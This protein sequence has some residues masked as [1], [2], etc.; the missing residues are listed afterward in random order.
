MRKIVL[1]LSVLFLLFVIAARSGQGQN[2]GRDM[3]SAQMEQARPPQPLPAP[4]PLDDAYLE[5]PLPP[6]DKAYGSIDG[7][8]IHQYVSQLATIADQYRDQGHQL[9][10]RITGTSGDVAGQQWLIDNF[11]R[12]GLTDVHSQEFDLAPQWIAQSWDVTATGSGKT[13]HLETAQP[14]SGISGTPP[15]GLDLEAVY[16]GLG[17]EA[18]FAGKDVR[19]KAVFVFSAALP[20]MWYNSATTEG[21]LKRA[22]EK[23]AAVIFDVILSPGNTKFELYPTGNKIPTFALG[24]GDGYA[25]R[26]AIEQAPAGQPPHVKVRLDV[27]M[28]PNLKTAT[29]W[30]TLPGMTDEKIYVL[31]HRDAWFEGATDDASGEATMLGVAEYFAKVPKEKRRRTMIFLGTTGHHSSVSGTVSGK[32]LAE[33]HETVFAKTALIINCEHTATTQTYMM[34][35]VIREANSTDEANMWYVGGS[36]KLTDIAVKAYREFGEPTYAE[37]E[38]SPAGEMGAFYRFA[39]SLQVLDVGMFAHS[40]LET[41]DAVP[42][43][44]LEAVVRS[45]AKIIDEVNELEIKDLQ[46]PSASVGGS[47]ASR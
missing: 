43:T 16:V 5:W 20:A 10:G 39:P 26:Q 40:D 25:V 15:E 44:G 14:V 12:I 11:K 42:W 1:L 34:R 22:E 18:D 17:S 32:W 4:F 47:G 28:V 3:S 6:A 30:G 36:Q 24:M 21:G 9:W 29:I 27:Q 45:Y 41:P 7:R 38:R 23:G 31:A 13:L 33:N 19:G 46:A 35:G 8:H 2:G 37:P